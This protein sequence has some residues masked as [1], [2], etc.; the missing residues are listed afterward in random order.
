MYNPNPNAPLITYN[1]AANRDRLTEHRDECAES[2]YAHRLEYPNEL[3]DAR[4]S[5]GI[6]ADDARRILRRYHFTGTCAACHR[7]TFECDDDHDGEMYILGYD[8]TGIPYTAAEVV[9]MPPEIEEAAATWPIYWI[10]AECDNDS[11]FHNL[12][13][14]QMKK[15][16]TWRINREV[17]RLRRL[18]KAAS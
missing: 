7:R 13:I 10:C 3:K 17:R 18:A 15:R 11:Y 14:D 5:R 2:Y 1:P 4:T 16:Y 9:N 12:A 8:R 6:L